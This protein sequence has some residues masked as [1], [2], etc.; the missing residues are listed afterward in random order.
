M[1]RKKFFDFLSKNA[2]S[3][4]GTWIIVFSALLTIISLFLIPHLPIYTSRD[5]MVDEDLA[6][7]KRY[8]EY[9]R[10]FGTPNQLFL[11]VEGEPDKLRPA[12]DALAK[13]LVSNPEWVK[14]VFY[15]IDLEPIKKSGLYYIPLEDLTKVNDSLGEYT[16]LLSAMLENGSLADVLTELEKKTGEISPEDLKDKKAMATAFDAIDRLFAQWLSFLKT[17]DK[18]ELTIDDEI[19]GE[20]AAEQDKSI[21]KDGYLIGNDGRMYIMFV[22]QSQP[23]DDTEFTIPF[24]DYC[25]KQVAETMKDFPDATVGFTGWPVFIEDEINLIHTD[26]LRVTMISG[27]VVLALFL[28]AFRSIHRT[29]LAFIPLVFGILW[30]LA[31]TLLTI[32]HLNY[33]TSVFVGI[34]FGLGIDY[35]VVFVRRYDE[36][37]TKGISPGEAVRNMLHSVGPS[38]S[39]GAATT[40]AAFFAIGLTDQ[41]AFSELGI[42]AGMGVLCVII[43]TLFLMPVLIAKFPPKLDKKGAKKRAESKL[44]RGMSGYYLKFPVTL[45]IIG[46]IA[47]LAFATQAPKVEFDYNLNKLLPADSEAFIGAQKMEKHTS[48]K[49][50]YVTLVSDTFEQ[51]AKLKPLL[52]TLPTVQRVES[53]SMLIPTDQDKKQALFPKIM[54]KLENIR[55]TVPAGD[56]VDLEK[57][58]ERLDSLEETVLTAQE[59]AFSDGRKDLVKHLDKI[60]ERLGELKTALKLPD[61]SKN[62]A[63]F[64]KEIFATIAKARSEFSDM[65]KSPPVSIDTISPGLRDRFQAS[66]GRFATY[67]FPKEQIWDLDFLDTFLVEIESASAKILGKEAPLR[68]TGFGVVFATTSKQI[69]DG[70]KQSSWMAALVVF[71]MLFLDFRKPLLVMMAATPVVVAIIVT[72]GIYGLLGIKLNMAS[73]ISFPI[74]LG[75]GVDYGILVTRRWMEKDGVDIRKVIS[76][77]GWAISLAAMETIAGFGGLLFARHRGLASFGQLLVIAIAVTLAAALIG[78]PIMVKALRLEKRQKESPDSET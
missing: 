14:N 20:M 33:L 67:I 77:V 48:Y 76:T 58:T 1:M 66:S 15:K 6:V 78:L 29:L 38:I 7:Q 41:P 72:M 45:F 24:M 16:G 68:T 59:D 73:Q 22:Q 11:M 53:I 42:V 27:I 64:E 54:E 32:G 2:T 13:S 18:A 62:E 21:D 23:R 8:L 25:R 31:L 75:I 43:S 34:L 61:A 69:R 46:V 12:V 56:E 28:L 65:C 35:G 71:I 51:T 49:L 63:R 44:L 57:L 39:T 40:I 60:V 3:S 37:S 4:R 10:E 17:P 74:L 52:D 70:F 26:L 47:V 19:F 55:L 30:S 36:E 5:G 50:Q 9:N